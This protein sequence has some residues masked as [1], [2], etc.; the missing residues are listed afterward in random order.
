MKQ[1]FARMPY[2]FYKTV[3]AS[4]TNTHDGFSVPRHTAEDCLPQQH[5]CQQRSSQELVA[6]DLHGTAL[7][8][9]L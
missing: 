4:D 6:K 2:M 3:T 9:V 1:R 5:H 8:L 7:L